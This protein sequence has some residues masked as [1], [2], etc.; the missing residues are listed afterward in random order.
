MWPVDANAVVLSNAY[1]PFYP[2][3]SAAC[4]LQ[5]GTGV[6]YQYKKF[7]NGSMY[8]SNKETTLS[9]RIYMACNYWN[10][11]S[12]SVRRGD[13]TIECWAC[14]K[15]AAS[16]GVA[17]NGTAGNVLWHLHNHIWVGINPTGYWKF[18]QATGGGT[19]PTYYQRYAD[20]VT[21]AATAASGRFD[22]V[23]VVRRSGDYYF[24]VNGVEKY[25]MLQGYWGSYTAGQGPTTNFDVDLYD[26]YMLI[27]TDNNNDTN[28]D[29]SGYVQ[30][31]RMTLFARYE[32][33]VINNIPTM[34][35]AQTE[36][37]ALPTKLFPTK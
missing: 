17:P 28:T 18:E 20:T 29:W 3:S 21:P 9:E 15:D 4:I 8:F 13:W 36:I 7:G 25:I 23:V 32:T 22:H 11:Q 12:M 35:H 27:G 37:P 5:Y 16:G 33:R 10:S 26:S 34:V 30:D 2:K 24:Y 6:S 31:F 19:A 1:G 14:W